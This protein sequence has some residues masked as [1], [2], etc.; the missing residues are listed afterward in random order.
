MNIDPASQ[1]VS[2]MMLITPMVSW[3]WIA[4]FMMGIGGLIA[5]V[6]M[7]RPVILSEAKDLRM[8]ESFVSGDPS[9]RSG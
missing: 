2:V 9:L 7:R 6:P 5:L 1:T 4:V 8:A 3:I